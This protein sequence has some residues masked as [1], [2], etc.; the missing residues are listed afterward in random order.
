MTAAAPRLR[1]Q[2]EVESH[3][4]SLRLVATRPLTAARLPFAIFIGAILVTGL[5]ALLLLHTMA[6]QDAFRLASLEKQ[7]AALDDTEQQLALANQQRAAPAALGAHARALGMVAT[8]SIA[9][10]D[11]HHHGKIVGVVQ[12]AQPP[13]PPA[14]S[15]SASPSAS[16]N[17]S[18]SPSASAQPNA[19]ANAKPSANP[20]PSATAKPSAKAKPSRHGHHHHG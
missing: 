12:A 5:I 1:P 10:V 11:L 15:P 18:A 20:K 6:A 13:P 2:A 16:A 8:G 19:A 3:R 14:P 4:P 9:Y 7:S 17:P